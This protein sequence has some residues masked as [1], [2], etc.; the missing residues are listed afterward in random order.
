MP[1]ENYKKNKNHISKFVSR[2]GKQMKTVM[3][4]PNENCNAY[5]CLSFIEGYI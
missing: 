5:A 1:N 3:H 4:M 2:A